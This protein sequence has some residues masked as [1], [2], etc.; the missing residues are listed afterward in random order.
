[1][2]MGAAPMVKNSPPFANAT[3]MQFHTNHA[4]GNLAN[5]GS[6]AS[7]NAPA[8]NISISADCGAYWAGRCHALAYSGFEIPFNVSTNGT[9]KVSV[10][11]TLNWSAYVD[12]LTSCGAYSCSSELAYVHP[13]L[14]FYVNDTTNSTT[15][16]ANSS[17]FSFGRLSSNSS[18]Y[19]SSGGVRQITMHVFGKLVQGHKY[20][21]VTFV[22]VR[23]AAIRSGSF[24]GGVASSFIM[25]PPSWGGGQLDWVTVR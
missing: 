25:Q 21:A 10:N 8:G 20:H 13:L 14:Y 23:V 1:M 9:F 24:K 15:I 17:P 12:I 18:G 11:W 2:A 7:A 22:W 6:S 5:G 19:S 16:T 3:T 4:Y